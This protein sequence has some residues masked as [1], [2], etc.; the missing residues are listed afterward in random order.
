MPTET[1]LT[2][3][4]IEAQRAGRHDLDATPY[5]A[6][7]RDAAYRMQVATMTALGEAPALLKTIITP[8]GLGACA[9]IYRSRV[10]NSGALQLSSPTI[11]GL[12]LEVGL[13]LASDLT[14][15]AANR[16]EI[17][18]IEAIS[19]YFV[20]IEVC[21]TRYADRTL[22]GVNGGLA[23]NA[24]AF[25]YVIDPTHRD[26]GAEIENYDV[27]LVFGGKSIWSAPA[28]HSF[29]T[30][31]KSFVAYAKN[32]HPAFPLKAGTVVTTG[33]LCGLVPTTGTGHVV[34]R[35]GNHTVSFDIA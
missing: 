21:G 27:H 3:Q 32:Q 2:Q 28:K 5:S 15:E 4:L 29:G 22:S 23:D 16:D 30:V 35:L 14:P 1:D 17:D 9:P 25:G 8:D 24:S 10:G 6:I 18:I 31:L 13:V 11:T 34:G 12:E 7:D 20:G 33:S 19:H 26:A